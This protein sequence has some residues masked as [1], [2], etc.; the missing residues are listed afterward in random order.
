[1]SDLHTVALNQNYKIICIYVFGTSIIKPWV[2]ILN[3]H[4]CFPHVAVLSG[5]GRE[6]GGG[7]SQGFPGEQHLFCRRPLHN[8]PVCVRLGS[9]AQ[10]LRPAGPAPPQ[11]HGHYTRYRHTHHCEATRS[12]SHR[13]FIH[14]E[15]SNL[16]N[17]CLTR[18][19]TKTRLHHK[20]KTRFYWFVEICVLHFLVRSIRD[21]QL[22]P[23]V[24][25]LLQ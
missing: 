8:G 18:W 4:K 16:E 24:W 12:A 1:M 9:A 21:L 15:L 19:Q 5:S 14:S 23:P 25:R 2:H 22:K 7:Q 17:R 10:P 20:K 6:G 11:P 13:R 3:I